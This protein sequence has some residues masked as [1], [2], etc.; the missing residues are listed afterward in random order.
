MTN[1]IKNI[2]LT[3]VVKRP[4]LV[5]IFMSVILCFFSF[6]IKDF[7]L[8]ASA[9]SLLLEDDKDPQ[10]FRE[11]IERYSTKD[12]LFVTFTSKNDLFSEQTL[13]A[14]VKLRD[15]INKLELVDSVVTLVDIP[16][17]MQHDGSLADV[18]ENVRK[19]EDGGIDLDSAKKEILESPIYKE[20]I[21]S[22][23]GRTT[24]LVVNLKDQSSFR[25]IQNKRNKLLIEEKNNRLDVIGKI[26]LDRINTEYL[27]MKSYS[28]Q[29]NHETIADIREILTRYAE[30]GA[31]HLGG[32]PMIA[33]DMITFIKNDLIVF[34]IGVFLFLV[35]ML[36]II[37]RKLRWVALPLI[38]CC[39]AGIIMIGLLGLVGWNVTVISSNFIS[40]ML[41]ITMSMNVHLIVRYR[42]LRN[43]Y[44]DY[45]QYE[46]VL[47]LSLIHI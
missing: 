3:T 12:F 22:T 10:L 9:D 6:H 31:L 38:S 47:G 8:D 34:G 11:T 18:S 39:Y 43:D 13:E 16:L 19:I 26:E 30:Y 24:A 7:K 42:Q 14:I 46:L 1:I 35:V 4:F 23:D 41:I 33:D 21:I 17:V 37:F 27:Q 28:D 44:P 25:E 36:T 32:V 2:Y 5:L 20:L 29:L 45:N 40:L 15:E